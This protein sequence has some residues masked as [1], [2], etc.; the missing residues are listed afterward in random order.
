MPLAGRSTT[1]LAAKPCFGQCFASSAPAQATCSETCGRCQLR[2]GSRGAATQRAGALGLANGNAEC[3][4]G[5]LAPGE[6]A[7]CRSAPAWHTASSRAML[8]A[9]STEAFAAGGARRGCIQRPY[10]FEDYNW[11]FQQFT[12]FFGVTRE[13]E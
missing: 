8:Y 12:L 3:V 7:V 6:A 11:Y 10:F 9:S 2:E 5:A 1:E 4:R 13:S